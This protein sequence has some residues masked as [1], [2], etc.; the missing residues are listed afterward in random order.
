[1]YWFIKPMGFFGSYVFQYVGGGGG[2]KRGGCGGS[3]SALMRG[4]FCVEIHFSSLFHSLSH[5]IPSI[6]FS[7]LFFTFFGKWTKWP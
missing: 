5:H 1:M 7:S 3:E 2:G 6:H 4:G